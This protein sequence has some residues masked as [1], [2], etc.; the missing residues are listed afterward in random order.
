MDSNGAK[1]V[2]TV[3]G[4]GVGLLGGIAGF[5]IVLAVLTALGSDSVLNPLTAL[6]FLGGASASFGLYKQFVGEKNVL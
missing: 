2:V 1:L 3:V 6:G 4:F 5:V